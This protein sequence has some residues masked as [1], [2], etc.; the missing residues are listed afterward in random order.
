MLGRGYHTRLWG[1]CRGRWLGTRS[2]SSIRLPC[3]YKELRLV[4]MQLVRPTNTWWSISKAVRRC[5]LSLFPSIHPSP[6]K[7]SRSF[8]Y[9][10]ISGREIGERYRVVPLPSWI[11]MLAFRYRCE[12]PDEQPEVPG[13]LLGSRRTSVL[14]GNT[15]FHLILC[16]LIQIAPSP[17]ERSILA[18]SGRTP[19]TTPHQTH[20]HR[21]ISQSR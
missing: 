13:S 2:S 7:N 21:S 1:S 19:K 12:H 17:R 11:R 8:S 6:S 9:F 15:I 3:P 18:H 10:H 20:L 4:S 5:V 14:C 16:R